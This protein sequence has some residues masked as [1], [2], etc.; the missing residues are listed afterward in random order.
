MRQGTEEEMGSHILILISSQSR[1]LLLKCL[2][3]QPLCRGRERR[4]GE[5]SRCPPLG[6]SRG[7]TQP[8]VEMS[9]GRWDGCCAGEGAVA[10]GMWSGRTRAS[11]GGEGTGGRATEISEAQPGGEREE[12]ARHREQP[13]QSP[14]SR[15]CRAPHCERKSRIPAAVLNHTA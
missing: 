4:E 5:S 10:L 6:S 11:N 2:L 8:C 9:H 14:E 12:Q 15:G 7:A 1:S 13:V 3:F